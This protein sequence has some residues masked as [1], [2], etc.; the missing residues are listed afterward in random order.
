[1]SDDSR[2]RVP[3]GFAVGPLPGPLDSPP[4]SVDVE[5]KVGARLRRG[6]GSAHLAVYFGRW[7]L[8]VDE[9]IAEEMMDRAERFYRSIDATLHRSP[10]DQC[11]ALLDLV[12]GSAGADDATALVAQHHIRA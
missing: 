7:N 12:A 8:R 5:V 10:D 6:P 4:P 1:M 11:L 3:K 9:I 2:R